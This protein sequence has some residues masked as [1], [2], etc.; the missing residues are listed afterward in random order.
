MN[1][2]ECHCEGKERKLYLCNDVIRPRR[3]IIY[4]H[5]K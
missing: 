2:L 3:Q 5:E 1:K 4:R